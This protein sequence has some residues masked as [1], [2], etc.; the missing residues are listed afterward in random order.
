MEVTIS[1]NAKEI[2]SLVLELQGKPDPQILV[3]GRKTTPEGRRALVDSIKAAFE[4][5]IQDTRSRRQPYPT[6]PEQTQDE[7]SQPD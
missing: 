6:S 2:A 1:G 4:S 5:Q 3:T 7:E